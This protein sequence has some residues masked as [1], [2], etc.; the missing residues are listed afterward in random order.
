[1][2]LLESMMKSDKSQ[3]KD[4][5]GFQVTMIH[6]SKL[7]PSEDNN[8]SVDKIQELANAIL[9]SGSVKQNLLARKKSPDEY[10]LIAGHRRRLAAKYLVE[11][12][13]HEEFAM[14]PVHVEKS[15]DILSEID[16]ILTNCSARERNDWEK[17]ME[18]TRLT[19]LMKSLQSGSEAD[20]ERFRK[21]FGRETDIGGRE[22][23]KVVANKLGLSETKVAQLQNIERN[24]DPDLK[25]RFQA[26]TL[27]VSAANAA[28]SLPGEK[29]KE[30]AQ[31][32]KIE[33]ADVKHK[34]VS[35]SDTEKKSRSV[36]DSDTETD[37][38][39]KLSAYGTPRRVY[40]PDSLI[41][42]HGCMS[43]TGRGFSCFS[44]HM[45]CEIRGEICYCVEAPMGN[46]FPCEIVGNGTV[47]R[48]E[49]SIGY[50]C[51]FVNLDLAYRTAGTGEPVPCCKECPDP[52]EFA[53][54][55][56]GKA[57][58]ASQQEDTA[59]GQPEV[60]EVA[61]KT[62]Q[63]EEERCDNSSEQDNAAEGAETNPD[64]D[65]EEKPLSD[66]KLLKDVLESEKRLLNS[67]LGI[68]GIDENDVH[69]RKMKLK[70]SALASMLC[71]LEGMTQDTEEKDQLELP[72]MKNNDQRKAW[73]RNY[74]SWGIWYIDENIGCRYYKY[75]FDNGARL[76][77]EE[78]DQYN[79]YTKDTFL[80][81]HYHLVG[82]PEPPKHPSGG[83][84][85]WA[86]NKKYNRY[87][88][89]ETELVEF[90][91]EVQKCS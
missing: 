70:V 45:E 48:L 1:M 74:H 29:Q 17:M 69:I 15:D 64:Q 21:I 73:L 80:S 28:A 26:G 46:P 50:R 16:L 40:P 91:K 8:Y 18:V 22:L 61:A 53:C 38:I 36:S 59:K 43:G 85:K 90:L 2:A 88:N 23:R 12:L 76:I 35:E 78:Y 30:L 68:P 47:G 34:S 84:G 5:P 55:R 31:K 32:D 41:A 11:T 51:Q 13:G 24:L 57:V 6:Y 54:K 87:P 27:G 82:G 7:I 71:D 58:A 44:C 20:Q 77:V 10:E 52:C 56:S 66:L 83:Y 39:E 60:I 67:S 72:Y 9:L 25:E 81:S 62:Q 79:E 75:D 14:L 4:I 63:N 65:Q 89:S 33:L 42:T 37:V 19:D 3:K 49:K 86:W